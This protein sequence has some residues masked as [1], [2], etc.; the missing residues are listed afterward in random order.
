MSKSYRPWD[1]Q[2]GFLLPPSV[3]DFVPPEHPAHFVRD[4]VV[5]GL[6]LSAIHASCDDARGAPA[7]HPA[8]MT[9]LL[10]YGY[11]QGVI[12]RVGSRAG[13]WSGSTSRP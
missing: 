13:A 11:T 7:F 2:Q 1:V 8:M 4:L 6:D 9:A 10:L 12:L 3:L 5:N